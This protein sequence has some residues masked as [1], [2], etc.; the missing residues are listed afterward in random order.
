MQLNR[1]TVGRLLVFVAVLPFL[2]F[3]VPQ[4]V[5][6]SHSY[7]VLSS[8][9]SPAIGA[10]DVVFVSDVD[11][12]T[13]EVGDV[14]TYA[15]SGEP[16]SSQGDRITHRV[17]DVV[18]REDGQYF[19]T[20]GDANDSPDAALVPASHVVGRIVFHVPLLGHLVVAAGTRLGIIALVVAPALTLAGLELR[21]LW[22]YTGGRGTPTDDHHQDPERR[23]RR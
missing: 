8:S 6:A 11:P 12:E 10:G 14:V 15:P 16:L 3:A 1:H 17:V 2:A 19:E 18:E 20:K 21:D 23:T 4:L 9:M 22:Q 13:I 5:G 7:V